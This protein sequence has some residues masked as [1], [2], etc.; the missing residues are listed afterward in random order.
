[1]GMDLLVSTLVID[2]G[3]DPD[4]KAMHEFLSTVPADVLNS[5]EEFQMLH[6]DENE[7]DYRSKLDSDITMIEQAYNGEYRMS[8]VMHIRDADV[9]ITGGGSWGESPTDE[10]DAVNRLDQV[11]GLIAAGGFDDPYTNAVTIN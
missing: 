10:F 6:E 9:F 2:H 4:W 8:F 3:R 11:P 1:M 5:T 7:E